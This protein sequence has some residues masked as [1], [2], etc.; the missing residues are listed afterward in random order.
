MHCKYAKLE[1]VSSKQNMSMMSSGSSSLKASKYIRI[2]NNATNSLAFW[3]ISTPL[4]PSS[5]LVKFKKTTTNI[6]TQT[7]LIKELQQSVYHSSTSLPTRNAVNSTEFI[8]INRDS[9]SVT[10]YATVEAVNSKSSHFITY[11]P[12]LPQY[13]SKSGASFAS[14]SRTFNKSTPQ[15][16]QEQVPRHNE[17][18]NMTSVDPISIVSLSD[19]SIKVAISQFHAKN[20]EIHFHPS[21]SASLPSLVIS[22]NSLS[23]PIINSYTYKTTFSTA[24]TVDYTSEAAQIN[25]TH[26]EHMILQTERSEN[27]SS[28]FMTTTQLQNSFLFHSSKSTHLDRMEVSSH[29]LPLHLAS[30]NLHP[31]KS[32]SIS[33]SAIHSTHSL[34]ASESYRLLST[35][36][37]K[38]DPWL[39]SFT[40]VS[41]R[42]SSLDSQKITKLFQSD[43]LQSTSHLESFS[44]S[45]MTPT[46]TNPTSTMDV[47]EKNRKT[48][49]FPVWI[50]IVSSI[51]AFVAILI[52]IAVT[53]RLIQ[54]NKDH[55]DYEL[56]VSS[57]E[58]Q[59]ISP[60]NAE[61]LT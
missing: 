10:I 50:S 58:L 28:T 34:E 26:G 18:L 11:P 30:M 23:T 5:V 32:Q 25:I 45:F 41:S 16:V 20:T 55:G 14:Y 53:L 40:S 36:P 57:L 21:L 19:S 12:H 1:G 17:E 8:Y 39:F 60:R 38:S 49:G 43:N 35:K 22:N 48:K 52:I 3:T 27:Y 54:W 7:T 31:N 4:L 56:W 37:A 61:V 29:T 59:P 42:S 9:R 51:A 46:M 6:R 13:L 2:G 47:K 44:A 15:S 33:L 24:G